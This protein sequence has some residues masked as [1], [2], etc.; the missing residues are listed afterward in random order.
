MARK[1]TA[2]PPYSR[3]ERTRLRSRKRWRRDYVGCGAVSGG[4]EGDPDVFAF[5]DESNGEAIGGLGDVHGVVFASN[6]RRD[7]EDALVWSARPVILALKLPAILA[8]LAESIAR[9][10]D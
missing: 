7:G 1:M 6:D 9:W 8:E 3:Y 4:D 10:R 2:A 5:V